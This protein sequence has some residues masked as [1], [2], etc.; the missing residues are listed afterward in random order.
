VAPT[1][2]VEELDK[3]IQELGRS[4]QFWLDQNATALKAT[5]PGTEVQ[6]MAFGHLRA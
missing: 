4:V 1:L 6:K 3:R 2:N 5:D